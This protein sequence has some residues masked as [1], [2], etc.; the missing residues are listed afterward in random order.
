MISFN[1]FYQSIA[2]NRLDKWLETLPAQLA[3]WQKHDLHGE[4]QQWQKTLKV[5]PQLE[6]KEVNLK[7][8]VLVKGDAL[9]QGTSKRIE[10][11]LVCS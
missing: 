10:V 3:H 4:F 6:A 8:Q 5:L 11:L 7:S 9:D 2:T 1:K